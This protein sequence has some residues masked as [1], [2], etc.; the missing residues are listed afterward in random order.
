VHAKEQAK[1]SARCLFTDQEVELL[2]RNAEELLQL[3][4]H[5]VQELCTEL[6][7]LGFLMHSPQ[8]AEDDK[9]QESMPNT[10]A[11]IRV[12]STK[13]ATEVC[14]DLFLSCSAFDRL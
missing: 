14:K 6:A 9:H 11:A 5:F 1:S 3:H 2:T 7:P 8:A 10:D 12:V 13:F 4:E